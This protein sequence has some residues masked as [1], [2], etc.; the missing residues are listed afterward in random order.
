MKYILIVCSAIIL[1]SSCGSEPQNKYLTY[2]NIIII[3]D[4][5]DRLEPTINGVIQN[6]QYPPKDVNEIEKIVSF[7]KN[8][9]VKPGEKIGDKSCISFSTFSNDGIACIDIDK[10][11]GLENKQQF[12]NS[13]GKYQ[14]NGLEYRIDDFIEKV[15]DAYDSMRNTGLDLISILID[16]IETKPIIKKNTFLTDGIDTTFIN[17][18]NHI[19][20]F[21]DGYLEYWGK[22]LNSQYYFGEQEIK[23]VREFCKSNN[24]DLVTALNKGNSLCIPPVKN[25]NNQFV[26]LHILET[27][28]RDK[29]IKL[30]RYNNPARQRDNEILEAVWRK[31]ATDS[32][33]K[34]FE[35]KKY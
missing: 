1:F 24:V 21:T 17:Y 7:F 16:K 33:F 25:K 8:E 34:S 6:Q 32:N 18:E 29:N 19:Y 23:R 26:N 5:S 3:S 13:T 4:M 15:N 22:K 2:Q 31:W 28:E 9:C 12:I 14:N 11:K 35:W 30:Q 10:I 20:I 27:H